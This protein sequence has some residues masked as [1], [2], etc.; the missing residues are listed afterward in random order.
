MEN[1]CAVVCKSGKRCK[2]S[3][4]CG[5]HNMCQACNTVFGRK[6]HSGCGHILC[7]D[8]I[9]Y[10]IKAMYPVGFNTDDELPCPVCSIP[11]ND[12]D[13]SKFGDIFLKQNQHFSR[14]VVHS[15]SLGALERNCNS[16]NNDSQLFNKEMD[17]YDMYKATINI[18]S[19]GKSFTTHSN[20]KK[21]HKVYFKLNDNNKVRDRYIILISKNHWLTIKC[22]VKFLSL[23]HRS[24]IT[25]NH[26]ERK[27]QRGEF[28]LGD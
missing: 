13:W 6:L 28:D 21:T 7:N 19:R 26:P 9:N 1:R 8:C 18:V 24:V 27:F 5:L 4:R 23:H 16:L 12:T 15:W 22:A 3:I 11:I 20:W 25:A 14:T 17:F 10:S 2:N